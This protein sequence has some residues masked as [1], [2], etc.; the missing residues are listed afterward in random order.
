M[1][2]L[3]SLVLTRFKLKGLRCT[4]PSEGSGLDYASANWAE[5]EHALRE[6]VAEGL[7]EVYLRGV[8]DRARS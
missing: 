5:T 7:T 8:V 4:H 1:S 3:I 2:G 6:D